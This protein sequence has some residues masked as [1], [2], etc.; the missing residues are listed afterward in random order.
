MTH[1]Q[2]QILI[3]DILADVSHTPRTRGYWSLDYRI[4]EDQLQYTRLNVP[5]LSTAVRESR[6][7]T[8]FDRPD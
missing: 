2:K 1:E 3:F 6:L 7:P 5:H 8:S 4:Q